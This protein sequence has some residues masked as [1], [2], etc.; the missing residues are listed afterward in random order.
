[1]YTD[2]PLII[3]SKFTKQV[4]RIHVHTFYSGLS[5]T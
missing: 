4:K 1:M 2:Q 5:L 3:L